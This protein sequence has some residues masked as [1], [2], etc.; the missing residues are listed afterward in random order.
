M[1]SLPP[2]L[3]PSLLPLPLS[4][5]PL[6]PSLLNSSEKKGKRKESN[7]DATSSSK[8]RKRR[9][10]PDTP[11]TPSLSPTPPTPPSSHSHGARDGVRNGVSCHGNGVFKPKNNANGLCSG[12]VVGV[13][14]HGNRSKRQQLQHSNYNITIEEA[15]V[16]SAEVNLHPQVVITIVI[17]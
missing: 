11:L 9:R 16:Q 14:C 7:G 3:P 1:F 10:V 8:P 4:I 12:D 15:D 6:P 13:G 2:P 5:C 17:L